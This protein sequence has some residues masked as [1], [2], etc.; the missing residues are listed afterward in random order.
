M[1]I[2]F[3]MLGLS[4]ASEMLGDLSI[5]AMTGQIWALPFLIYLLK[6]NVKTTNRWKIWGVSTALLAY[7]NGLFWTLSLI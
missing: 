2:V 6:F 1:D 7:P 3:T 4:Y 5:T